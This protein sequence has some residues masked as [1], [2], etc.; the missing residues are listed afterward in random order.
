MIEGVRAEAANNGPRGA[1]V[2]LFR[3]ASLLAARRP[4][5]SAPCGHGLQP[6]PLMISQRPEVSGASAQ[7]IT[8]ATSCC[9]PDLPLVGVFVTVLR[10]PQHVLAT[11]VRF[12][13]PSAP[14][15]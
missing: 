10:L 13:C 11:L 6:G 15:A 14:S 3:S 2:P 12:L 9:D 7:A 8:S 4:F 5:C 1:M